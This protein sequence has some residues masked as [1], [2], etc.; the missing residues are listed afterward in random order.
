MKVTSLNDKTKR[1]FKASLIRRSC[2]MSS[3]PLCSRFQRETKM[4]VKKKVNWAR[5]LVQFPW[6]DGWKKVST[7]SIKPSRLDRIEVSASRQ[8]GE[9]EWAIQRAIMYGTGY[10]FL[11]LS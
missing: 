6:F 7:D 10:F 9:S 8:R 1:F 3:S 5:K 4:S 2:G 11:S